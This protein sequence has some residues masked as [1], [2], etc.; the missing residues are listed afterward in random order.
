[1]RMKVKMRQKTDKASLIKNNKQIN[2]YAPRNFK[3]IISRMNPLFKGIA[4]NDAKDLVNFLV[5]TLHDELN[6]AKQVQSTV[7]DDYTG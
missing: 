1:M 6:K 3:E 5:M 2:H 7:K 4:A